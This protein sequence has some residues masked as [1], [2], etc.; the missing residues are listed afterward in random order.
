VIAADAAV[1]TNLPADTAV[2]TH[3]NR[4][5]PKF[6]GIKQKYVNYRDPV[7]EYEEVKT[8]KWTVEVEKQLVTDNPKLAG[9]AVARLEQML[10]KALAAMPLTDAYRDKMRN[11][12][13]FLM[14]GPKA[15][16]D[17]RDNGA[18][19]YQPHAPNCYTNLDTRWGGGIVVYC[20][21]NYVWQTD[22]W[23]LKLVM[24]ELV[25]VYHLE[26]WPEDQ[27]DICKGYENAVKR[28]LYLNV[29]DDQG[30]SHEKAYAL[31]NPMEYFAELSCMYF[32]GCDYHPRNRK[33]LKEY[34]PEG[35]AMIQKFWGVKD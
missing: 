2:V 26:Q 19:Y 20:A 21:G 9:K 5:P 1:S 7:R 8:N 14:Y 15:K 27:A 24:H 35:Y 16:N 28:K 18:E 29:K 6:K 4:T 32:T 33:E 17:G 10:E 3:G 25:H 23:A 11:R 22:F 13:V 30:K 31:Q 12:K 34:D